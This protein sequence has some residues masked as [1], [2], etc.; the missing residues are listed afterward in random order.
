MRA[1]ACLRMQIDARSSCIQ[2]T[3]E[4]EDLPAPV[5]DDDE[6]KGLLD[7]RFTDPRAW[8]KGQNSPETI[9]PVHTCVVCSLVH[10]L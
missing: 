7:R 6:K 4:H 3:G 10:S 5:G 9:S 1:R 8:D 2:H